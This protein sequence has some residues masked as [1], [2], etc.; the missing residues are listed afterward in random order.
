MPK[1]VFYCNTNLY[2]SGQFRKEDILPEI[3]PDCLLTTGCPKKKRSPTSN[4]D[5]SK[6]LDRLK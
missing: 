5:Y 1:I 4:F 2:R 3:N 6:I